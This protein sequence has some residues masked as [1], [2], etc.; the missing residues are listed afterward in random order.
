MSYYGILRQR[1][2]WVKG[3]V[4]LLAACMFYLEVRRG[5]WIYVPVLLLVVL[6]CFFQKEHII[7]EAG[8]DIK[9]TLFGWTS[10]NCWS[11]QE[12]TTLHRDPGKARPNMMLHIGKGVVTRSFVLTPGDCQAV[13]T[14]AAK[15]NPDIY[16]ADM[17]K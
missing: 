14:L 4:L 8:A 15:M 3:V 1:K 12:I 2:P 13:L 10:H 7:S 9:Y 6:A 16:I 11:W 5:Q 17:E